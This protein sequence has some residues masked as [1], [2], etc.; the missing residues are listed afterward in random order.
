MLKLKILI[1]FSLL[2]LAYFVNVIII[3]YSNLEQVKF[4]F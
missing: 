4:K 3:E 1:G 2:S